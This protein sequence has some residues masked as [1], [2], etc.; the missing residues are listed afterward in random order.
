MSACH[1][2]EVAVCFV[3]KLPEVAQSTLLGHRPNMAALGA[4]AEVIFDAENVAV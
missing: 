1:K 2:A 4:Q 3:A